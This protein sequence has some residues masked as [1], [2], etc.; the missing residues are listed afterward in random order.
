VARKVKR[1]PA[2]KGNLATVRK[3]ELGG[4]CERQTCRL[5]GRKQLEHAPGPWQGMISTQ[6][7]FGEAQGRG[8]QRCRWA[9]STWEVNNGDL[10]LIQE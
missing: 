7:G 1:V 8:A 6:A 9:R 2:E 10:S 3:R 4:S 5:R